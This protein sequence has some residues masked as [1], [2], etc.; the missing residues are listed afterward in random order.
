MELALAHLS[1]DGLG[2]II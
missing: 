2:N 1:T